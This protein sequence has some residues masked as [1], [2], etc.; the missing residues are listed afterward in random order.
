[1]NKLVRSFTKKVSYPIVAGGLLVGQ[2]F[3]ASA[4]FAQEGDC[5]SGGVNCNLSV[6]TITIPETASSSDIT[7]KVVTP[8]DYNDALNADKTYPVIYVLHGN[9][10]HIHSDGYDGAILVP[11]ANTYYKDFE[12][13]LIEE[14]ILVFPDGGANTGMWGDVAK[15]VHCTDITSKEE[16]D[17][18]CAVRDR[19]PVLVDGK[20][21]QT[22]TSIIHQ[23]IPYIEDNYRVE[24]GR[25]KRAVVGFSM[26]G[27]GAMLYGFKH[28]E[29]FSCAVSLD[30]A[31][32]TLGTLKFKRS[33]VFER[34][35]MGN[36]LGHEAAQTEEEIKRST[37]F[38]D[39]QI[40]IYHLAEEYK[41]W[42]ETHPEQEVK[43]RVVGTNGGATILTEIPGGP[44]ALFDE[45]TARLQEVGIEHQ[46]G[47]SATINHNLTDVLL[48]EDVSSFAFVNSCFSGV[49]LEDPTWEPTPDA[50]Y[51]I[52]AGSNVIFPSRGVMQEGN[53]IEMRKNANML[54]QQWKFITVDGAN[55]Y[56]IQSVNDA[57]FY[58][59]INPLN[60]S[61]VTLQSLTGQA[62]QV[63]R[64]VEGEQGSFA[65]VSENNPNLALFVPTGAEMELLTTT[66]VENGFIWILREA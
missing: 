35:Y 41:N 54:K 38:Y 20:D 37:D 50:A 48:N 26:G 4:S 29:M 18:V 59:G 32:H 25:D 47:H 10:V 6:S 27:Y 51:Y 23:V 52:R 57:N 62:N 53:T 49:D 15:I 60:D 63:W 34:F 11:A 7:F 64:V 36:L 45:F 9:G 55:G 24:T 1:M 13:G 5:S 14:S 17:A 46:A 42:I 61:E 33:G 2:M 44:I 28:P 16:E 66:A 30:G 40:N 22:E 31:L 43:I 56:L 21:Y 12:A 39:R 58:V 8:A 65:L 19:A 3:S